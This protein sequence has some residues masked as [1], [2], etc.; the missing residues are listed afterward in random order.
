MCDIA[1]PGSPQYLF[2]TGIQLYPILSL[3]GHH[4][5]DAPRG[6]NCKP[7]QG[8]KDSLCQVPGL[9]AQQHY[10]D[11]GPVEHVADPGGDIQ[12]KYHAV[13]CGTVP[14]RLSAPCTMEKTGRW[15]LYSATVLRRTLT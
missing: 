6:V 5:S 15:V 7:L 14:H 4:A 13:D 9:A 8:S 2:G 11:C 12:Y 3:L 1:E 10:L